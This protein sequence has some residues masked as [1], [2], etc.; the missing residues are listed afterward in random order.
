MDYLEAELWD[1]T[2]SV[3]GLV[4]LALQQ[5]EKGE[6]KKTVEYLLEASEKL[7]EL[8]VKDGRNEES[9]D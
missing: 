9:A 2:D 6:L 5:L 3:H 7:K 4:H 8:E 1:I